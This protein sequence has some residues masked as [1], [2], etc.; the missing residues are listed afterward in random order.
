MIGP[1]TH[2]HRAS[3][4]HQ[5]SY[6][7]HIRSRELGLVWSK[8]TCLIPLPAQVTE[9]LEHP[10]FA[11]GRSFDMSS[12]GVKRSRDQIDPRSAVPS[13]SRT[14][15]NS[16]EGGLPYGDDVADAVSE[17]NKKQK[18]WRDEYLNDSPGRKTHGSRYN[19]REG[20]HRPRDRDSGRDRE[21][22]RESKG[23]YDT[24]SHKPG[25]DRRDDRDRARYGREDR[26][27]ERYGRSDRD[28]ERGSSRRREQESTP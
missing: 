8:P 16:E 11:H 14:R 26:R 23:R 27:D 17:Q 21:P 4:A 15:A 12:S 25:H 13:S 5:T 3:L 20:S 2:L 7:T 6:T 18:S 10:R 9:A 1:H 19:D 28:H 24:G 22:R